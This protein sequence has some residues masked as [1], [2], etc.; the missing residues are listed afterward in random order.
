MAYQEPNHILLLLYLEIKSLT[1]KEIFKKSNLEGDGS[2]VVS[3][4]L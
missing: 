3:S 1:K 2:A 4:T